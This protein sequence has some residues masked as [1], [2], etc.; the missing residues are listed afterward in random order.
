LLILLLLL[1]SLSLSLHA[2]VDADADIAVIRYYLFSH[3]L[4]KIDGGGNGMKRGMTTFSILH[5]GKMPRK[6]IPCE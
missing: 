6:E 5:L 3:C 2:V 4:S 1:L